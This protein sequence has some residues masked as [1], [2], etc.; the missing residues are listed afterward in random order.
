MCGIAGI[1]NPGKPRPPRQM[2]TACTAML[3]ALDFR[4]PD[5]IGTQ[6]DEFHAAGTARLSITGGHR[7]GNQPLIDGDG[8]VFVFNGELYEPEVV[9]EHEHIDYTSDQSDGV[10]LS[11]IIRAHGPDGL[12]GISA[13]F[14]LAYYDPR[15]KSLLLARDAYGQKPLYHHTM[16]DGTLV[17]GS[18]ISALHVVAGP[19]AVREDAIDEYLVFKSVGGCA[20]GYE[21]VRQ[22][23]P[24][25]WMKI[26]RAGR[27][28]QGIWNR[29]PDPDEEMTPD[30]EEIEACILKAI[31]KRISPRFRPT[32]FLSGGL[33]SSI[34]A[35][36]ICRH[37]TGGE[38]PLALSIGYDIDGMEDETGYAQRLAEEL[39]MDYDCVQ[40]RSADVPALLEETAGFLEDPIQDPITVPYFHICRHAANLTRVV[41]TGDGSDEF[42][43]G[44]DRFADAPIS[45]DEYLPRSMVFKPSEIG[46]KTMP[47]HYLDSVRIDHE[48][49][50]LDRIL[51]VEVQNRLRN[52]HL[53][54]I[55]KLSMAS[56]LEA[57]CPFLDPALSR[58]ALKIPSR[59]KRD[60]Q[61]V[62]IPLIDA[63]KGLLPRWLLDRRKQPFTGP[64][65]S[66]LKSPLEP[67][68]RSMNHKTDSRI[69]DRIDVSD[70][71]TRFADPAQ[72]ASLANR[73]WSLV[74][75]ET[76]LQSV[77]TR[78]NAPPTEKL[79]GT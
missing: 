64:I 62:K 73:V 49:Q 30:P 78:F 25:S 43:G 11:A 15:E 56:S 54:R 70:L 34:V 74:Y 61:R 3:K 26:D 8:G 10:A 45:I 28:T 40:L 59:H 44:Y 12:Q 50:P 18:T 77:T 13:M 38:R 55:D 16:S 75:L 39:G 48:L 37:S 24:G 7:R 35:A 5:H 31:D 17:F 71:L 19:F 36:G 14:A 72:A 33:D 42:W 60:G 41:L 1:F 2:D 69:S 29:L 27:V 20:S 76:W 46:R 58:M 21:G 65:L 52:Y 57:R 66:W 63:S 23:P 79:D 51:R 9:A 67:R 32:V 22:L 68:L 6:S 4:G 47:A 53:A